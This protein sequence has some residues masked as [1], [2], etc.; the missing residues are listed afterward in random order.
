MNRFSPL[1]RFFRWGG[2][3]GLLLSLLAC[4]S[5]LKSNG[6]SKEYFSEAVYGRA[7]PRVVGEGEVVPRGGGQYLVGKP[8]TI[9]GRTYYPQEIRGAFTQTGMASWYGDAF[10]GRRT[11]NGEIYDKMGI[12]A[13]HPTMPLPSYARI[14]NM[15]NGHSLIVRVNDRGPYHSGR[16]MDVSARVA[17]ALDFKRM[18]TAQVRVDYIGRADLAGSNYE[19]LLKTLRTDGSL[20]MLE[21]SSSRIAE[22]EDLSSPA[23]PVLRTSQAF[24]K[25]SSIPPQQMF[26]DTRPL[27][28]SAAAPS[29][30]SRPLR[31][32]FSKETS[33]G[34]RGAAPESLEE[35]LKDT[36]PKSDSPSAPSPLPSYLPASVPLPPRRPKGIKACRDGGEK[37][38]CFEGK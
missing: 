6:R 26:E 14:T 7:S 4:S 16:V 8:Y 2:L 33:R 36:Q 11:A 30:P 27:P 18:G 12:S 25:A 32:S 38:M 20:A 3:I 5:P 37:N 23:S 22:K 35:L 13:A 15:R 10:H 17:E 28:V 19:W 24:E 29:L 31:S 9:A 34:E 21:P 1:S